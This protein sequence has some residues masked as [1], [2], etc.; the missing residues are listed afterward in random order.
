ML[1]LLSRRVNRLALALGVALALTA[2]FSDAVPTYAAEKI[3]IDG[4]TR[5]HR[6]DDTHPCPGPRPQ[7][8]I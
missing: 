6:G 3:S 8:G 4:R 1:V 7:P 2:A 5:E